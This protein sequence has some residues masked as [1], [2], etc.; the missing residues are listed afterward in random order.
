MGP[1]RVWVGDFSHQE[2]DEWSDSALLGCSAASDQDAGPA[3]LRLAGGTWPSIRSTPG[4]WAA[5][6]TA[7]GSAAPG[8]LPAGMLAARVAVGFVGVCVGGQELEAALQGLDPGQL[9]VRPVREHLELMDGQGDAK[10]A[11]CRALASGRSVY[12]ERVQ[13]IKRIAL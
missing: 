11:V 2:A 10:I 8:R 9:E 6:V 4:K 1:E 12:A 7:V 3:A 5:A 13:Y